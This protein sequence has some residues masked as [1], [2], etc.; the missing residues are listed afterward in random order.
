MDLHDHTDVAMNYDYYVDK[1][2]AGDMTGFKEFYLGLAENYGKD[3]ILDIACGTGAVTIPLITAGFNVTALDISAPMI[4]VLRNKLQKENLTADLC[5]ANMTDFQIDSKFSLVIIAR[6]GFMHLLMPTAQRQ[7]LCN[8]HSHLTEGGI[9]TLNHF[10]PNPM[11]QAQQMQNSLDDYTLRLEYTNHNGQKERIYNADT[12]DCLT[13][14]MDANWK[15]ETLDDNGNI[16][17]VRIRGN[18]MRQTYMQE[19]QYLFE[20]CGFEVVDVYNDYMKNPVNDNCIWV[21]RKRGV[22]K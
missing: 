14:I 16:I 13:Q 11:I 20:L 5:A 4:E 19:M 9:L 1:I 17:D 6:S 8:I 18:H 7:A 21:V 22:K 10:Q 3:G 15:Y 2:I 12:Y